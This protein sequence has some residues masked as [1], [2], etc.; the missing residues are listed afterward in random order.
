[1]KMEICLCPAHREL[2]KEIQQARM[3]AKSEGVLLQVIGM[4]LDEIESQLVP[5]LKYIGK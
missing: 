3:K 1:M 5:V 4:E 2:N